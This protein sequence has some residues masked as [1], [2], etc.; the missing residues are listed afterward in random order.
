M[1]NTKTFQY[2]QVV[3]SKKVAL[4]VHHHHNLQTHI[5]NLDTRLW[6]FIE[7]I[8]QGLENEMFFVQA[9]LLHSKYPGNS[10]RFG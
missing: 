5:T 7:T 9:S 1:L 3:E 8:R 10:K 2:S 6:V 4:S